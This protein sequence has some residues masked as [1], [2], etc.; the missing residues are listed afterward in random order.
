MSGPILGDPSNNRSSGVVYPIRKI[1]AID[2]IQLYMISRYWNTTLYRDISC[3]DNM[4]RSIY[5]IVPVTNNSFLLPKT[6]IYTWWRFYMSKH[7]H[8]C[9]P[10]RIEF[11]KGSFNQHYG[12]AMGTRS[13][14]LTNMNSICLHPSA[15]WRW[16]EPTAE[17]ICVK[18]SLLWTVLLMDYLLRILPRNK[19][20]N[21]R[22][23]NIRIYIR[24]CWWY[25]KISALWYI[26]TFRVRC[27][28]QK[29]ITFSH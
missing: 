22:A 9:F 23:E 6:C 2:F 18:L 17:G 8:P 13:H 14:R 16:V 12:R 15:Y 5:M 25:G 28:C 7:Q 26:F 27:C 21:V 11:A 29:R 10:P 4:F 3:A 24:M 20:R 19:G 1:D